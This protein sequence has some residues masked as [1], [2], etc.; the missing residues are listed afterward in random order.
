MKQI[1]YWRQ[2]KDSDETLPWPKEGRLPIETKKKVFE[3][4][5]K[6]KEHSYYMGFSMCR[7]CG[8]PNGSMCLTDGE[9]V[10]PEGYAH[11][12]LDHNVQPDLDLLVK[13]LMYEKSSE[14]NTKDF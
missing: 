6:G 2:K 8:K 11:Y 14:D 1:G 12:I 9:F 13:V 4:L 7:I 3:Y 5:M 10:Y